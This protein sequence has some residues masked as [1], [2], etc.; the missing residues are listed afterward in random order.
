LIDKLWTLMMSLAGVPVI[1]N[2]FPDQFHVDALRSRDS[3]V[4]RV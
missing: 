4:S 1:V 2:T 3:K